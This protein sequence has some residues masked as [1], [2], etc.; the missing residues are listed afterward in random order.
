MRVLITGAAGFIGFHLARRLLEDGHNVAGYDNLNAYYDPQLKQDRLA[1]LKAS[2]A[3]SMHIGDLADAAALEKAFAGFQPDHVVNLAAQAGV[4]H[5]LEAPQDY[6]QGNL[7]GFANLLECCRAHRPTHLV[8]A[9]TSS[10]YG[11]SRQLPY[12]EHNVCD[13]Q[14]NLYAASKKANE[15]MAHAYSHLFAIP[16][17]GL[18][19]FTVYGDWGRPDMAFFK[20]ANAIMRGA[21]IDIYNHGDMSRDFTYVGDIVEGMV[22]VLGLPPQADAAWEAENPAPGASGVAPH[23]VFNI[24]NGQPVKLMRYIEVL[25]ACLGRKAAYNFMPMQP[26]DVQDTCADVSKLQQ[27]TGYAPQTTVEDGLKAFADWYLDYYGGRSD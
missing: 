25:E 19:F 21:P 1:V 3:F 15:A 11:A 12:A 2:P 17:T 23:R 24:G 6:V 20:F 16:A 10:I 26:G 18:R 22:R 14:L 8:Y 9:S 27:A 13:H 4:R 5:S 7:V